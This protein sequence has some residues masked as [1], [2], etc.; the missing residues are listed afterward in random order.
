VETI[1]V[2]AQR[3]PGTSTSEMA[4]FV[5]IAFVIV[6]VACMVLSGVRRNRQQQPRV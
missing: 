6:A 1:T 2:A 3:I 5:G 4:L